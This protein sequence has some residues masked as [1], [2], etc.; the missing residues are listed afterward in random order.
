MRRL[1]WF[2]AI[3]LCLSLMLTGCG[4]VKGAKE[5]VSDLDQVVGHM[6]SYQGTGTMKIKTGQTEQQYGVEVW[7]QQPSFYR[8]SL[9]NEKNDITQIVL[10]NEEGVFVLTPHLKKSF[11]FQSNWPDNQGQVYLYQSLVQS[12]LKDNN[13]KF[14][15]DKKT[16]VFDVQANYQNDTLARQKIWLAKKDYAPRH[17]EISDTN[18]KVMVTVDFNDFKFNKKF[19]KDSFDMKRNMTSYN[20]QKLQTLPTLSENE[21][22]ADAAVT[23]PA[24][25]TTMKQDFGVLEPG[26][27]PEGV[28]LK[29]T[30]EVQ[31]GESKAI[32]LKYEGDYNYTLL[33]SHPETET[34]TA[35]TGEPIE[36][37]FTVGILVGDDKKTLAWTDEGIE[38]RLSSGD[39]PTSEMV[40]I[41]QSLQDQVGK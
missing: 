41:A 30:R 3:A 9:T 26:Y 32:L 20:L 27:M 1:T 10:R 17:I 25:E 12:I 14:A 7:Y 36:L 39:L 29:D 13:R 15:S 8:I 28:T 21:G 6:N 18:S 31:F 2:A 5:V 22:E 34:V 4:A 37:G 23:E 38:Y 19:E 40:T 16:Y 11:R 24:D 35:S 33:E